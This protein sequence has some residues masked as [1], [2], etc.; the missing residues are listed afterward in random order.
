MC[1][2]QAPLFA[3]AVLPFAGYGG[4]RLKG[5]QGLCVKFYTMLQVE[6]MN[7]EA[8]MSSKAWRSSAELCDS[9]WV[10]EEVSSG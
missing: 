1:T 7:S 6:G 9:R 5:W 8:K 2:H 3:V 10:L 4:S